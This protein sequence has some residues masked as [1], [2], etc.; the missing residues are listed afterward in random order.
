MS[1]FLA[2]SIAITIMLG[3]TLMYLASPHQQVTSRKL[4][5]RWAL[6][7]GMMLLGVALMLL[8]EFYGAATSVFFEVTLLSLLWTIAPAL[9]AYS[10]SR[11]KQ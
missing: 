11:K 2:I 9:F 8:N 7:A 5:R 4:P 3:A 1:I 6:L 10:A